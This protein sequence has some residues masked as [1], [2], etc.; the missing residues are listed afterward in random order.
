[1][2]DLLSAAAVLAQPSKTAFLQQRPQI[3]HA[4]RSHASITFTHDDA[5]SEQCCL[6]DNLVEYCNDSSS[7]FW[8]AALEARP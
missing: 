4:S 5:G 1:M 8:E 6:R 3:G 2:L 7:P